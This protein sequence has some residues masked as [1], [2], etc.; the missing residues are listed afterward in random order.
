MDLRQIF[1]ILRAH[2]FL[3]FSTVLAVLALALAITFIMPPTYTATTTVV[4]DF[5][6]HEPINP[7]GGN[8]NVPIS[9]GYLSTQVDIAESHSVALKVV[10]SL[11]LEQD[12]KFKEKFLRATHGQGSLADWI[13]DELRKKL[14]IK[15][16]RESRV[17]HISASAEDAQFSAVT[18]DAFA[19]AFIDTRLELNIEPARRNSAWLEEQL[20]TLRNRVEEAQ[21]RLTAYQQQNQILTSDDRLDTEMQRYADLSAQS[22][23]AQAA[24]QDVRSRQL[25]ENHPA[26]QRAIARDQALQQSLAAQKSKILKLKR[27]RDEIA[28]LIR[29]V[30]SAQRTYDS[31]MQRFNQSSLES[32]GNQTSVSVLNRA[33]VPVRPSSPQLTL[34]LAVGIVLGFSLGVG[35]ALL[36]EVANRRI[37]TETDLTDGLGLPLFGV[38]DK[39]GV[40]S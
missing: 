25:G 27:G 22:S 19:D 30:E 16:V 21:A 9:P 32:Q 34:N 38:L 11:N 4:I 14:S 23:A 31:A 36:R 12:A 37:R 13:A 2:S 35:A 15:P 6:S 39:A 18:S 17:V 40:L 33:V 8:P 24:I 3:I 7:S 26:Y 29:E 5:E 28:V 20:K 10:K 1:L